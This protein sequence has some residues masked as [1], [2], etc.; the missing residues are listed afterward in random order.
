MCHQEISS[1]RMAKGNSSEVKQKKKKK[2]N[3]TLGMKKEQRK[4]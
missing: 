1:K 4:E 3:G 2:E